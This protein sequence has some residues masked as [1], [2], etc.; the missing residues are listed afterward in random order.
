M[1]MLEVVS[2]IIEGSTVTAYRVGRMDS[3]SKGFRISS[4]LYRVPFCACA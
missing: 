3:R 1:S 4:S 2:L